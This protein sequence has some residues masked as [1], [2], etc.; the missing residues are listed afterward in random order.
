MAKQLLRGKELEK[1]AQELGVSVIPGKDMS[2]AGTVLEPELQR[3]VMEAER[4]LRE[5]RL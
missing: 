3:R 5:Q 1:R 4:S 2:G